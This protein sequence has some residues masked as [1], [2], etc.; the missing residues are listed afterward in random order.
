M[1]Y[2]IFNHQCDNWC[3]DEAVV[4]GYRSKS[5]AQLALFVNFSDS[6]GLLVHE[7]T[8]P[9]DMEAELEA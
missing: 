5:S 4:A 6:P 7:I 9:S 3:A 8:E 1:E 2:G